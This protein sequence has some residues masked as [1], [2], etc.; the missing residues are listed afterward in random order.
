MHL[1]LRGPSGP[2]GIESGSGS[3]SGGGA[4]GERVQCAEP[5]EHGMGICK[6]VQSDERLLAALARAV[7]LRSQL[8]RHGRLQI[9]CQSCSDCNGDKPVLAVHLLL[10]GLSALA[11]Q[12]LDPSAA[13][14]RLSKFKVRELAKMAW[15]FAMVK[16]PGEKLL[17]V[18]A[19]AA[20][21]GER[22]Q[23]EGSSQHGMGVCNGESVR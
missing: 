4:A 6:V 16:Q 19:R 10:R 18:L 1:L 11:E 17:T 2:S 5:R 20:G 7:E 13:K 15:A 14:R 23:H 3:G 8:L 21:R 12:N 9:A 22:V